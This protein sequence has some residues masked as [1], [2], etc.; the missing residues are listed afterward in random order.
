MTERILETMGME[1]HEHVQKRARIE[2]KGKAEEGGL[3]GGVAVQESTV[4]RRQEASPAGDGGEKGHGWKG[5]FGFGQKSSKCNMS[6]SAQ[7]DMRLGKFHCLFV[8]I[9]H[10]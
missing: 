2:E 10:H 4:S 8:H 7:C 5:T 6:L 9:P 3:E 1:F